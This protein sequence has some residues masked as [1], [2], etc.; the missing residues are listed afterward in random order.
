MGSGWLLVDYCHNVYRLISSKVSD[1]FFLR[2][3]GN[4]TKL[5]GEAFD[6][7]VGGPY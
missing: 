2:K 5:R 7:H 3:T 1:G 6:K 4:D